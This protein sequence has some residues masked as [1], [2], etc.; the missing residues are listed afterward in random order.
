MYAHNV[1]STDPRTYMSYVA[2]VGRREDYMSRA[3]KQNSQ[4]TGGTVAHEDKFPPDA[5][6]FHAEVN[7]EA[8]EILR[9]KA[10]EQIDSEEWDIVDG[11]GQVIQK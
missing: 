9:E 6:D 11:L 3:R 2:S 1:E 8:I 5:Y 10:K 4:S 7:D